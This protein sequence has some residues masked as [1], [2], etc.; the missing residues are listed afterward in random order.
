MEKI[1]EVKAGLEL[2]RKLLETVNSEEEW[3]Y[4]KARETSLLSQST[5][6]KGGKR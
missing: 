5:Q 1:N 4:W 3:N 6:M 2:I